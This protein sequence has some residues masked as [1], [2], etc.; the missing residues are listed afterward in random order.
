M[1]STDAL[2][3]GIMINSHFVMFYDAESSLVKVILRITTINKIWFTKSNR[4]RMGALLESED[5]SK[6]GIEDEFFN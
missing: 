3:S 2:P 6:L 4:V 5:V 1:F